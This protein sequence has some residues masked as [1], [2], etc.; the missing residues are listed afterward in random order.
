MRTLIQSAHTQKMMAT[1][2]VGRLKSSREFRDVIALPAMGEISQILS[3]GSGSDASSDEFLA[4]Q[5]S[6]I[7]RR[8]HYLKH[9]PRVQ[10]ILSDQDI[11]QHLSEKN[12]G[13]LFMNAKFQQLVALVMDRQQDMS[14]VNFAELAELDMSSEE[15][16]NT[17]LPLEN[18]Q[19]QEVYKWEDAH[20][21]V[22]YSDFD[23]IPRAHL[24]SAQKLVK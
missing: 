4:K 7:W 8:I 2:D 21:N 13:A 14:E 16:A 3:G 5:L 18:Y 22:R 10:Q 12:Y 20:G 9:D 11:Q 6:F 24:D 19:P 15:N 1:N 17:E 23:Q